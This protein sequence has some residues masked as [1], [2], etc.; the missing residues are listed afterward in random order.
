MSR[1]RSPGRR[2]QSFSRSTVFTF[3]D[4]VKKIP[5]GGASV[6]V[7]KVRETNDSISFEVSETGKPVL[8]RTSYFPNWEVEGAKEI[9][10]VTPNF[11]VV[12]PTAKKVTLTY[13]HTGLELLAYTLSL[14]G[15]LM[16]VGF[17]ATVGPAPTAGLFDQA[18]RLDRHRAVY[19]LAHVV[20]RQG[21]H[22]DRGQGLHLDTRP[23]RDAHERFNAHR[24][25][26]RGRQFHLHGVETQRVTERDEV[27]RSLGRHDPSQAGDFQDVPLREGPVPNQGERFGS[28]PNKAPSAGRSGRDRLGRNVHHPACA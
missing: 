25:V 14:L 11:M 9:T 19:G 23:G 7:S 1:T 20:H 8:I 5:T 26:P 12:T 24:V 3:S 16:V 10:R 27:A 28:H 2:I 18:N 21:R 22:A 17:V 6:K 15:F 13:G 4:A